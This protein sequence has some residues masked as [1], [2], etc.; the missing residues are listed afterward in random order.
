[1]FELLVLEAS[2]EHFVD[3]KFHFG[4]NLYRWC[5][6]IF[7]F[8]V[9]LLLL[10]FDVF[11]DTLVDEGFN[12]LGLFVQVELLVGIKSQSEGFVELLKIIVNLGSNRGGQSSLGEL[13]IFSKRLTIDFSNNL[14]NFDS[15][16]YLHFGKRVSNLMPRII[17][18]FI[19]VFKR[20][21][22]ELL[23]VFIEI[24]NE[25]LSRWV[26]NSLGIRLHSK[27]YSS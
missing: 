1:M 24:G 22:L 8:A 23:L 25:R 10:Q 27:I 26:S 19:K 6:S 7:G 15:F 14:V 9:N 20:V 21:N 17:N 18:H 12:I 3:H 4:I 16:I 11:F 5:I 13:W 2:L